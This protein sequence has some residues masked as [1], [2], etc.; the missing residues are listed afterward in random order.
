MKGTNGPIFRQRKPQKSLRRQMLLNK[1]RFLTCKTFQNR[2]IFV[3][4]MLRMC[5]DPQ[6]CVAT[7]TLQ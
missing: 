4:F 3:K 7:P 5:K 2:E 1:Q 6:I